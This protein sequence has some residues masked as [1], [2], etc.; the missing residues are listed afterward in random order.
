MRM[1]ALPIAERELLVLSRA[2]TTWRSRVGTSAVVFLFGV[3]FALLYHYGGQMAMTQGMRLI[4]VF[5]SMMCLFAGVSFT[6][7][8]IAEEKRAGTLG[9]LFLTHQSPLQIVLGKLVAHGVLGFYLVLC[10]LPLLS[11]SM[12]FGGMRFMDVL[13]VVF[14]ALNV[15]F[16]SAAVGLLAS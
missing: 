4:G 14:V 12:I 13:L 16:F 6:A 15:L 1:F 10:A 7:D 11:M 2:G 9:L 3:A 8:S 5:L